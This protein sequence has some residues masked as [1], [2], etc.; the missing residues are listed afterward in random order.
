MKKFPNKEWFSEL[1]ERVNKE[2]AFQKAARWFNGTIGL[3][4]DRD[5]YSLKISEGR[6]QEIKPELGVPLFTLS[7]N[8]AAWEELLTM[9]TINRLFR[10]NKIL[11]EGDKVTAMRYWKVLWY[12]TEIARNEN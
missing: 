9:G 6:V 7:G 3:R 4:I 5:L 11:I 10:Q 8:R 1:K 2:D 12:L